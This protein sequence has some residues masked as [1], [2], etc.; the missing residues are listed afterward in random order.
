MGA[1]CDHGV[2]SG[3]PSSEFFICIQPSERLSSRATLACGLSVEELG[4]EEMEILVFIV[5][6]ICF[7]T[8]R[9]D[10]RS[11]RTQGETEIDT[12]ESQGLQ[13]TFRTVLDGEWPHVLPS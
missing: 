10:S 5:R 3:M 12:T 13:S 4:Q 8:M 11:G 7:R 1:E 2:K 6:P 9:R